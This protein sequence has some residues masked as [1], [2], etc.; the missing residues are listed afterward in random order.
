MLNKTRGNVLA[1]LLAMTMEPTFTASVKQYSVAS[2]IVVL[3]IK[4]SFSIYEVKS[5]HLTYNKGP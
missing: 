2:Y 3:R 1:I 4:R 5:Y